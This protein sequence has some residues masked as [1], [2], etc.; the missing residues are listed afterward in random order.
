MSRLLYLLIVCVALLGGAALAAQPG[1]NSTL[2]RRMAHPLHAAIISFGTG[3]LVLVVIAGLSGKLPPRFT[4][5]A[6]TLPWWA[7]MGGSIGAYLVTTSILFAPRVGALHW[8]ALLVTGQAIGSILLDHFGLA[9]F[10]Q[11]SV[12]LGR[13]IGAALLVFGLVLSNLDFSVTPRP[14]D[15]QPPSTT[16]EK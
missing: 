14:V 6:A 9:G 10:T 3:L 2:S 15:E 11:R 8:I 7:W 5:S 16:N 12:T 13:L 4:A 1:V